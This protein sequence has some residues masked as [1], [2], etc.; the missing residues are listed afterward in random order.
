MV[1]ESDETGFL[2]EQRRAVVDGKSPDEMGISKST[3]RW[4]KAE[5]KKRAR[6]ALRELTDVIES[7][8]F[9]V[10]DVIDDDDLLEFIRALVESNDTLTDERRKEAL[11]RISQGLELAGAEPVKPGAGGGYSIDDVIKT[12]ERAGAK[13][14]E[15]VNRL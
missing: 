15:I 14:R 5:T 8:E 6:A 12:V 13:L 3:R 4:H 11:F 7:D 10:D 1:D 9:D 2:T